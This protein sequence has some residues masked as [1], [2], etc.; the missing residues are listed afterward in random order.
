MYHKNIKLTNILKVE[1]SYRLTDI[2]L[3]T[4]PTPTT[5]SEYPPE[6]VQTQQN[7]YQRQQVDFSKCDVYQVGLIMLQVASI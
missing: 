3:S 7:V 2:G 6:Y 5:L 1:D 4:G